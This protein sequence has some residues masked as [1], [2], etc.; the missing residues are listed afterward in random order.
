MDADT[1]GIAAAALP[2]NVFKDA[3]QVGPLLDW[4]SLSVA[5][6]AAASTYNQD[7]FAATVSDHHLD[8]AVI[9]TSHSTAV[10]G[11]AAAR[12]QRH[13]HLQCIADHGRAVW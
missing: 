2:T 6:L 13:H 9:V 5:S 8:A 12:T 4:M 3:C 1:D 11:E 7:R 10:G